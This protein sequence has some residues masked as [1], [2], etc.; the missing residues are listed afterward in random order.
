M[1]DGGD[2]GISRWSV[3]SRRAV[4]LWV[5]CKEVIIEYDCK[6]DSH[7]SIEE[8]EYEWFAQKD[9]KT[10]HRPLFYLEPWRMHGEMRVVAAMELKLPIPVHAPTTSTC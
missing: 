7:L 9:S 3:G 8:V 6:A 2:G 5:I 4:K 1:L 10:R